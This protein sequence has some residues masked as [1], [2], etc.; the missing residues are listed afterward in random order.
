MN[1]IQASVF[2]LHSYMLVD[3]AEVLHELKQVVGN[4]RMQPFLAQALEALPKKNSGGYV[5]A[6]QQQ[7]DEFSSTVLRADTTKAISQALK[8][9]T[10][11]FR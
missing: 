8:T 11:L 10:R 1:L 9:F 4:E 2:Q 6:T 3:V 7:L 5:T